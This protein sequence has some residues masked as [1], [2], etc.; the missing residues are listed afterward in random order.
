MQLNFQLRRSE[1]SSIWML[2]TARVLRSKTDRYEHNYHI[3]AGYS[4]EV[5]AAVRAMAGCR[6]RRLSADPPR[7][8]F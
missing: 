7:V 3:G 6:I 5:I 4:T 8:P 1:A 2:Q